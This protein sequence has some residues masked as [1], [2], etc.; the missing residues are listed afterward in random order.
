MLERI[1]L[2]LTLGDIRYQPPQH[3]LF[4]IFTLR[5]LSNHTFAVIGFYQLPSLMLKLMLYLSLNLLVS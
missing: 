4:S 5:N 1:F 2:K 3:K